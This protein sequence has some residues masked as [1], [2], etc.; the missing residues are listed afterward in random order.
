MKSSMIVP[1]ADWVEKLAAR[2]PDDLSHSDHIALNEHL[3]SCPTCASIHSAY[4]CLQARI[5]SLP[6]VQP[7]PHLPHEL[8]EERSKSSSMSPSLTPVGILAHYV[9]GLSQHVALTS[10]KILSVIRSCL[11]WLQIPE[12]LHAILTHLPQQAIYASSS[13]HYFYAL[14]G[15]TGCALW[16]YKRSDVFFSAPAVKNGLP[17]LS[18]FDS[19]IFMFSL[20]PFGVRPTSPSFL[21]KH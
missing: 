19:Q 11:H 14:Q 21:W 4:H 5:Q 6:A 16:K 1:C 9:Q 15:N 2:H 18:R 3:A 13:D 7:L 8:L 20:K 12:R 10:M 17:Y